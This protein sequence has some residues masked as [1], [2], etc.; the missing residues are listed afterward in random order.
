MTKYLLAILI[1]ML[2]LC[3]GFVPVSASEN[4]SCEFTASSSKTTVA[5]PAT[6]GNYEIYTCNLCFGG[7]APEVGS[8]SMAYHATASPERSYMAPAP[9]PTMHSAL[10]PSSAGTVA[11][12]RRQH[13]FT[14]NGLNAA[15]NSY[16]TMA[17]AIHQHVRTGARQTITYLTT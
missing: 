5:P 10:R 16:N 1:A 14:A 9:V 6:N 15:C 7:G 2:A 12:F 4:S 8:Y 11:P 17:R 13:G 3:T